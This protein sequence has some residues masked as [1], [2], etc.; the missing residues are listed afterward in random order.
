MEATAIGHCLLALGCSAFKP[1]SWLDLDQASLR[2][3]M[4]T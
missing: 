3:Y 2:G 1:E 4:L